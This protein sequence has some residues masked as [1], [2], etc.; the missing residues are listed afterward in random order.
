MF[1]ISVL[2]PNQ[3][4]IVRLLYRDKERAVATFRAIISHD[5]G[6][7]LFTDDSGHEAYIKPGTW[8]SCLFEDMVE[9]MN[10]NTDA[11]ILQAHGQIKMQKRAAADDTIRESQ[12]QPAI[13]DPKALMNGAAFGQRQ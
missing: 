4:N 2:L 5:Q 1:T 6:D 9:A 12:R 10:A 3:A 8:D 11:A 13:V 7:C